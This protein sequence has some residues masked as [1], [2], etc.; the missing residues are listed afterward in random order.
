M[1]AQPGDAGAGPRAG[2]RRDDRRFA[3]LVEVLHEGVL[4]VDGTGVVTVASP[5]AA[6]L[7]GLE[8]VELVGRPAAEVFATARL[9]G[10]G[11]AGVALPV[12]AVLRHGGVA[13]AELA[14]VVAGSPRWLSM[15]ARQV[16]TVD[17]AVCALADV[18]ARRTAERNLEFLA[19]H[20]ALTGLANRRLLRDQL[21]R[22]L[23]RG[24]RDGTPVSVLVLDLDGFKAVN[25]SLG[26]AAGDELLRV[27][28]RRLQGALRSSD[29]VARLGGDE[30]AVVV[31][32]THD[33][34]ALAGRLAELVTEPAELDGVS[35]AVGVSIGI[36]SSE[37]RT[38]ADRVL[39]EADLAMYEVKA[40]GKGGWVHYHGGLHDRAA[41]RAQVRAD[42]R[43]ALERDE[44]FVEYQPLVRFPGAVVF[45]AEALVRWRHPRRGV[46]LPAAFV[47]LAEQSGQIVPV[48]R[49]VLSVV[50]A[51]LAAWVRAGRVDAGFSV[52]VNVSPRQLL[53]PGYVTTVL[54]A[55]E[56][57]RLEG[58]RLVL[59]VTESTTIADTAEAQ[60]VLRRL[61][62]HGVGLALDD[63]GSVHA[64]ITYL[65]QLPF[66]VLKVDRSLV[67]SLSPL[68]PGTADALIRSIVDV[69]ALLQL[70]VLAEGVEEPWQRDRLVAL[71]CAA[72]QGYLFGRPGPAG[73][74]LAR[75][76][77]GVSG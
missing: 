70:L 54:G 73:E 27:L 51:E 10:G 19:Y 21:E 66:T 74:L 58:G 43:G 50:L 26:H 17:G 14:V 41:Q 12:L 3:A 33:A 62:D 11:P 25:D 40:R 22:R 53:A 67:A 57:H 68:G 32:H 13:E 52:A 8:V 18:T 5:A 44:L 60:Q 63:Y 23:Q 4:V 30:F 38:D 6:G 47:E 42:L 61:R 76:G 15:R 46:L 65:R 64:S 71:G 7:L 36:A 1:S 35:V 2:D 29:H 75:L 28:A 45:G 37:G 72:A 48:D 24:A 59:E 9:A 69:A 16:A 55:L 34:A 20:D 49:W 39:Q 56:E 77:G 31:D